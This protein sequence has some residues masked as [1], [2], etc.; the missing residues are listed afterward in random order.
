MLKRIVTMLLC[1]VLIAANMTPFQVFATEDE[2]SEDN[3]VEETKEEDQV[4]EEDES[5]D[6]AEDESLPEEETEEETIRQLSVDKSNVSFGS[7]EKSTNAE[8]I[9][10]SVINKGNTDVDVV[11]QQSDAECALL[12]DI[13][14]NDHIAPGEEMSCQVSLADELPPGDYSCTLSFQDA[15]EPSSLVTV[16]ASVRITEAPAPEDKEKK[17]QPEE[18]KQDDNTGNEDVTPPAPDESSSE[19]EYFIRTKIRPGKAGT[20][21]GTGRYSKGDKAILIAYPH[22]GY[23]FEGWYRGGEKVGSKDTLIVK[24][25]QSN[26]NYTAKFQRSHYTIKVRSWDEDCGTVSGGGKYKA[27]QYADLKAKAKDGY[28]FKGWFE[29]EKLLSRDPEFSIKVNADRKIWGIFKTREHIVRIG[30]TPKKAGT[31][32]GAGTYKGGDDVTITAE[33]KEGYVFCGFSLNNQVVTTKDKYTV[34]EIDR[35]LSFTAQFKKLGTTYYTMLS[36]VANKGGAI[37]PSGEMT[38]GQG[39]T[40]IYTIC[41]KNGYEVQAVYVDGKNVGSVTSY[42]F[43]DIRANH[44]ITV[45]FSPKKNNVKK[46]KKDRVISVEEAKKYAVTRL[47]PAGD[48]AESKSSNIITPEEYQQMKDQGKLDEIILTRKQNRVGVDGA[49]SLPDETDQY[50]YDEALGLYQVLD[51]SPDEVREKLEKGEDEE[52]IRAAYEEEV[53]NIQIN[54]QYLVPG[55]EEKTN[56]VFEDDRTIQNMLAFVKETL[57]KE[58]KAE[59]ADGTHYNISIGIVRDDDIEEEAKKEMEKAG[60]RIDDY[61]TITVAKQREEE[62]PVEVTELQKP[63]RIRM[64]KAN[65]DINCVLHYYDGKVEILKDVGRAPRTI[66]IETAHFSPFAFA[67]QSAEAGTRAGKPVIYILLALI[68]AA[69][70]GGGLYVSRRKKG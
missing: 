41:P 47:Y 22:E 3:Y 49:E 44:K 5:A 70:L 58:E 19:K 65:S 21:S 46:V 30:V 31:V 55:D 29:G 7:I 34:Q 37:Y 8:P 56:S 63:V 42:T 62:D 64:E 61:F 25:I 43:N 52:V 60:A 12:L 69:I 11:W 9:R 39:D 45:V 26:H 57:T 16:N 1:T 17:D 4:V 13:L 2:Y 23:E 40:A 36:G 32:T 48:D 14:S 68:A 27:G 24:N 59:I 67:H 33:P 50:N 10:F 20:V 54:N 51:L 18:K 35:D 38:I 66:T 6:Q 28:A 53:L 15:E